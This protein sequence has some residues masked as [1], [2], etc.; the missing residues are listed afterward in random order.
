MKLRRSALAPVIWRITMSDGGKSL[1]TSVALGTAWT[2]GLRLFERSIGLVSTIVLARLLAPRDFGVV[3]MA[4]A[5]VALLERLTA[6]GVES[7]LISHRAPTREHYDTAWTLSCGIGLGIAALLFTLAAPAA[8]F[9][10]E[11]DVRNVLYVVALFPLFSGLGN[12]G[13]V[14][15]RRNLQFRRDFWVGALNKIVAFLVTVPLA[16]LLR[17]YW[18]LLAGMLAG[19]VAALIQSYVV[20]PYRPR[21]SLAKI[22]EQF[23]F[24]QWMLISGLLV[25]LRTRLSDLVLGKQLGAGALGLFNMGREIGTLPTGE[26]VAPIN[27]AIFPGYS[28]IANDRGRLAEGFFRVLAVIALLA[29]PAGAGLGALSE[30]IVSVALGERWLPSAGVLAIMSF[31]GVTMALQT[32]TGAVFLALRRPKLQAAVHACTVAALVPL[33]LLWSDRYGIEGAAFA[34]ATSGIGSLIASYILVAR[35]LQVQMR[36]FVAALWR[37]IVGTAFM[38]LVVLMTREWLGTLDWANA[39]ALAVL[40]AAGAGTYMAIVGT[41]WLLAGR[42]R[43]A[44]VELYDLVV[45]FRRR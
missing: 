20:H 13:V 15:F 19:R 36:R 38:L 21:F 25:F 16:F 31:F 27:R 23:A 6:L 26:L 29:I 22:R 5:V 42:P 11:P 8:K 44:E 1:T 34:F 35:D 41:C 32:N 24:S 39:A 17:N 10:D 43:G 33:L 28:K 45:A 3:A 7:S 30:L 2:I 12:I 14:D 18:A 4:M 40:V 37:P 9:Y